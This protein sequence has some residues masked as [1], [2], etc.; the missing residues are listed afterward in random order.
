[1][2]CR[3]NKRTVLGVAAA[4]EREGVP[5]VNPFLVETRREDIK[6]KGHVPEG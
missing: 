3:S 6:R 1:M 4:G 5:L 2:A